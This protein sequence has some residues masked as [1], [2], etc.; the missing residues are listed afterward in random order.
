MDTSFYVVLPS[1]ASLSYFPANKLHSYKTKIP[2][3]PIADGKWEVGMT[4]IQFPA[5]WPNIMNGSVWIKF[6]NETVS[7]FRLHDGYYPS[8]EKLIVEITKVFNSAKCN[9]KVAVYYDDLRDRTS[10]VVGDSDIL[11]VTF[12]QNILQV[13]GFEKP[14]GDF[15]VRGTYWAESATDI[16]DGLAGL[17]VYTDIVQSR[18]VGDT[19]VP[20]LRVVPAEPSRQAAAYRWVNFQDVQ[21]VPVASTHADIVEVNIR[22]DDGRIIPFEKGKVSVT[23]RFRRI[24]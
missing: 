1:N 3:L 16:N 11:G 12:S 23:L 8:I 9:G 22:R 15:F 14:Q 7:E 17:F 4:E 18:L 2:K 19:M 21:Y 5:R 6:A 13:M 20:L 24:Q 10:V